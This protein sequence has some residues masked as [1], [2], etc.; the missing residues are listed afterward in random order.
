VGTL[1]LLQAVLDTV[2][3]PVLAAGGLSGASGLAAALAAGAA[4]GWI[5]TAFLAC[6][7]AEAVP[8]ARERLFAASET[9][10]AYGRVFDIGQRLDWPP[11]YGGRA[12]RNPFFDRWVDRYEALA[13]DEDAAEEL[14]LARQQGDLD[15]IPIYAGQGVGRLRAERSAAE[16]VAELAGAAA[17]LHRA[18]AA[19]PEA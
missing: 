15:V 17:L 19:F 1:V 6:T 14:R 16:V 5:G 9:D 13:A 2:S 3:V 7:E 10:T 12:L 4:G 11:E 8:S 18:A